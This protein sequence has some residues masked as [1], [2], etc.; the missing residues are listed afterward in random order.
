ME[1]YPEYKPSSHR[2]PAV[3][4]ESTSYHYAHDSRR[5]CG[6]C[7]HYH[8][9][10]RIVWTSVEIS[11]AFVSSAVSSIYT[12]LHEQ[13]VVGV[14]TSRFLVLPAHPPGLSFF[15]D[16]SPAAMLAACLVLGCSVSS[17]TYRHHE[18]DMYQ[19]PVFLLAVAGAC[20]IGVGF[21][22]SA[23]IILLGLIPWALSLA[24]VWSI[25]VHWI[26]RR[27]GRKRSFVVYETSEKS[28]LL[29]Y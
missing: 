13:R 25:A 12:F 19:I 24:M 16:P 26:V 9:D 15:L 20:F 6:Y 4:L 17:F 1:I 7:G 3:F 23:N 5:C 29:R 27:Y 11:L 2:V 8:G 28:S 22:T 14:V 18:R 10:Q 21:H